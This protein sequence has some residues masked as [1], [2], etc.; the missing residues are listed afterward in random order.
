[1]IYT[2]VILTAIATILTTAV[3]DD[4]TGTKFQGEWR[5]T[6]GSVK[7]EQKGDVVSG[8]YGP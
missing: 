3:A 7:L 6:L 4:E 2:T 8:T 1:M 5:T